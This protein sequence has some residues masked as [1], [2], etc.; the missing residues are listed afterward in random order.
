[1]Y[2]LFPVTIT[3]DGKKLPLLRGWKEEATTDQAKIN[4]W[5]QSFGQSLMFFG[6]PTGQESG[7]IAID[8]DVKTANGFES[9]KQKGLYL[10]PTMTQRTLSG[11]WHLIVLTNL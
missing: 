6:I 7:I 11:G 1:M 9:A 3:P 2:R 8:I 10:P 5:R 4:E